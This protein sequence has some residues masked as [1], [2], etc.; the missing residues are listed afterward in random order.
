MK[1]NLKKLRKEAGL[2]MKELADLASI[3]L[4]QAHR[5]EGGKANPTIRTA[6]RVAK[7]LNVSIVDIWSIK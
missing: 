6:F 1:S 7:V 2:T 3:A 4:S 5:L